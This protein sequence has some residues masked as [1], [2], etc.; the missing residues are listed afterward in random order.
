MS[1]SFTEAAARIETS[2]ENIQT[3]GT[4]AATWLS[5]NLRDVVAALIQKK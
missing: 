1:I 2:A 5:C 3:Q 4:L